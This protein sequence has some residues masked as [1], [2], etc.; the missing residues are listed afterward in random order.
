[1][2]VILILSTLSVRAVQKIIRLSAQIKSQ[3]WLN[4]AFFLL[5]LCPRQQA[6]RWFCGNNFEQ[7]YCRS[8]LSFSIC[9]I[10]QSCRL[11]LRIKLK[12]WRK[13]TH[14]LIS[15]LNGKIT[16]TDYACIILVH[17]DGQIR[18]NCISNYACQKNMIF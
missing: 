3:K 4:L 7:S 9:S 6:Y 16:C 14:S 8:H 12:I 11:L 1:M 13:K 17:T 15:D 5:F 2:A 10:V 18:I